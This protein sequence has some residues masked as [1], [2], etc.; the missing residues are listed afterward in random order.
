MILFY[1]KYNFKIKS[2]SGVF[3][4]FKFSYL[5]PCCLFLAVTRHGW[6]PADIYSIRPARVSGI[7]VSPEQQD[8]NGFRECFWIHTPNKGDLPQVRSSFHFNTQDFFLLHLLYNCLLFRKYLKSLFSEQAYLVYTNM[9]Q[10][11]IYLLRNNMDTHNKLFLES[12]S[13]L[14]LLEWIGH[15]SNS[16]QLMFNMMS[17]SNIQLWAKSLQSPCTSAALPVSVGPGFWQNP[18]PVRCVWVIW[19]LCAFPG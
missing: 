18:P 10:N 14:C 5:S 7:S 4:I 19:E 6:Q 8:H 9:W 2:L 13:F 1:N 16:G 17:Y 3:L 11:Y 12:L 15:A